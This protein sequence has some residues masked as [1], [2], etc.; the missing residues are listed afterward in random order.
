M[1]PA[2]AQVHAR[3]ELHVARRALPEASPHLLHT[4]PRWP[5]PGR[6][7]SLHAAAHGVQVREHS[8]EYISKTLILIILM[9]VYEYM[10]SGRRT[11]V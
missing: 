10:T 3:P 6:S 7:R 2:Q 8:V 1:E 5:A 4:Q 11:A 9:L